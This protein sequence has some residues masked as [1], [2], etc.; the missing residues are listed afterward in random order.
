MKEEGDVIG[1]ELEMR[2]RRNRGSQRNKIPGIYIT[3][4]RRS[5]ETHSEKTKKSD[6]SNGRNMY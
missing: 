6:N 4:E 2:E 5:G 3:K 1:R